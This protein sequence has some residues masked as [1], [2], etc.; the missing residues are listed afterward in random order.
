[1]KRTWWAA[2]VLLASGMSVFAGGAKEAPAAEGGKVV[3]TMC[4]ASYVNEEW[5]NRMNEAFE[6][7][8]GIHVEVTPTPGN[9]DDHDAKINIDL[10]AGSKVDVIESLG[11]KNYTMRVEGKLLMPL[12][13]LLAQAGVDAQEKWGAS[14]LKVDAQGEFYGLPFKMEAWCVYYNKDLFDRYGVPYPS[15]PWTWDEYVETAK[16]LTHPEDGVYG[17]FMQPD[18]QWMFLQANQQEVPFYK[19][20]GSCNFDDPAFKASAEWY[21]SLGNDLK[22][23]MDI[24]ECTAE[25]V[26]WNYYALAGDHLA[27]FTQG[28]WFTRLLN[29]QSD[30]PRDWK[31]GV[32]PLPSARNGKND[33]T[34]IAYASI[35]KNAAHP[36]E[37]LTYVIWLGENQW[38]Y[39]GGLPALRNLTPEQQNACFEGVAAASDG[40]VSVEDLYNAILNTGLG[41]VDSDIIGDAAT[42]YNSIIQEELRSYCM[43]L[44][45][46]DTA[47]GN[48]VTRT[49]EAIKNVR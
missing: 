44:Q 18:S 49:N 22:V 43:D 30:Y 24:A 46:I 25:N 32:A 28:N 8:T 31:Y 15:G 6:K 4:R 14:N 16:K 13:D 47:I 19:P 27:M 7:E 9:D 11:A 12:K 29:S 33:L 35:N 26:S 40:Q 3:T 23:Q 45:D 36:Q 41:S 48:I 42:E 2:A 37:A 34:S 21:K 38:R 5:Y 1:M 39:E 17:S 10:M 20:D